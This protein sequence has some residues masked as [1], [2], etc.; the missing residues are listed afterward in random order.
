MLN[1]GK[2][3]ILSAPAG[4]GKTTL[5]TRLIAEV[6][7]TVQSISY[8]SRKPRENEV[9]GKDYFFVTEKEFE[10][11]VSR[12]DFLEY[13]R[14]YDTYYG[15]DKRWVEKQVDAGISVF[16]VIDTQGALKLKGRISA[17]YI[18]VKPPSLEE[19]KRRI[20]LRETESQEMIEKRLKW[21]TKELECSS[22]YDHVIVNDELDQAY[23]DL[24]KIVVDAIGN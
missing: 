7:H 21:A 4:T 20:I 14:L 10:E 5:V 18:F 2:I 6:P 11:K 8:T 19:L 1:K 12:G 17:T 13:V 23:S 16:L 9:N 22:E 15:T 24:K 3:F